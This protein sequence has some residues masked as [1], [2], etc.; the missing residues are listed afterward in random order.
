MMGKFDYDVIV[1]GSGFGGNVSAMRLTDKGYR[2][3]HGTVTWAGMPQVK[4]FKG[5]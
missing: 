4:E 1:G 5:V 2:G 3:V